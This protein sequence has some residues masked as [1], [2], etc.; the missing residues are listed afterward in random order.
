MRLVIL[1]LVVMKLL[2]IRLVTGY[3]NLSY[4]IAYFVI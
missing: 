2:N 3:S 4:I 1:L